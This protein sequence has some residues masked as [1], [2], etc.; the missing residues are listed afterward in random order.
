MIARAGNDAVPREVLDEVG[1]NEARLL[2]QAARAVVRK[3]RVPLNFR[4]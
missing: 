2:A 3:E 4:N 1:A